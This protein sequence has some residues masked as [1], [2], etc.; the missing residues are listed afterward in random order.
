[1]I[2]NTYPQDDPAIA[3]NL[4]IQS[5]RRSIVV[6]TGSHF[7]NPPCIARLP[8]APYDRLPVQREPRF[9]AGTVSTENGT[10]TGVR[11]PASHAGIN[12]PGCLLR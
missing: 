1:M 12:R 7:S 11:K 3:A 2:S 9:L 4:Q 8:L 6:A 10:A 5:L